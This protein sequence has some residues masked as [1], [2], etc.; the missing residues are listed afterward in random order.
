MI[1]LE[2]MRQGEQ[3][4]IIDLGSGLLKASLHFGE[5]F[6]P[7]RRIASSSW[8]SIPDIIS[9]GVE[10]SENRFILGVHN[11]VHV[12]HHGRKEGGVLDGLGSNVL[13]ILADVE[14]MDSFDP[15]KIVYAFDLGMPWKVMMAI[16][17]NLIASHAKVSG[18]EVEGS[19]NQGTPANLPV[20]LNPLA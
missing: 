7:V 9:L 10:F 14:K 20:H 8:S 3:T 6:A 18:K 5:A 11:H 19:V 17:N 1:D 12:M 13:S 2:W 4:V 15:A 16:R